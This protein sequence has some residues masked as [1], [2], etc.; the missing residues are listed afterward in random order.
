MGTLVFFSL[1]SFHG[2][3][4]TLINDIIIIG[5]AL[6]SIF[7]VCSKEKQEDEMTR[8]IRLA[9]LLNALYIYIVILITSTLFMNGL[10][11]FQFMTF[12]LVLLPVIFVILFRLEMQRYNKMCEG[13]E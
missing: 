9:S 1:C 3:V 4:K 12:N 5:I 7:I 6:G 2:T 10:A 13:E 8:S 11:Y